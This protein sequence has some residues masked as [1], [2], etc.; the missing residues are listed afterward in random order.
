VLEDTEF[1][2]DAVM[3]ALKI[4]IVQSLSANGNKIAVH[5]HVKQM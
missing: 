3:F 2:V 4:I 1:S 5:Y